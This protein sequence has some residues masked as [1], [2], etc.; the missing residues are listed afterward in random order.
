[1]D[2][3]LTV[4][5]AGTGPRVVLVHGSLMD[6]RTGFAAQR[7][8]AS[9]FRLVMPDRR[10]FGMSPDPARPGE[11]WALD[12]DDL[13]E[14]LGEGAHLVGH[15]YGAVSALLVAGRI[16]HHVRSLCVI[17]PPMFGL[18][19]LHVG[20]HRT[21][22]AMD[23]ALAD[24]RARSIDEHAFLER[25]LGAIGEVGAIPS[26]LP[27]RLARH[28]HALLHARPPWDATADLAAIAAARF[29]V[30]LI[31]GAH[32][33]GFDAVLD[34]V[35]AHVPRAQIARVPGGHNAQRAADVL[36]PLLAALWMS[37]ERRAA[38]S[39]VQG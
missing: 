23:A 1:M 21:R 28:T 4:H 15:S 29:P 7:P 36:N 27:P 8:L 9:R 2:D 33:P 20:A 34:A 3:A 32:D 5:E 30:L 35:A 24:A 26:P 14:V 13:V 11:D 17:E 6:G 10:G 38:A 16:P 37:G 19:P 39:V 18:A 25:F 22:A 31:S 12:A